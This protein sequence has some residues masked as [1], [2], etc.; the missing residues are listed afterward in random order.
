M[1]KEF[2]KNR[3]KHA[4]TPLTVVLLIFLIIWSLTL[5][6]LLAWSLITSFKVNRSVFEIDPFGFFIN[7]SKYLN[8]WSSDPSVRPD[9][10]YRFAFLQAQEEGFLPLYTYRHIFAD[11]FIKTDPQPG[12]PARNVGLLEMYRNTIL[13]AVGSSLTG[14][15]VPYITAYCCARFKYKFSK[16]LYTTV[17]I[18]MMIPIVGSTPS[19]IRLVQ[20]LGIINKVY[21]H[22]IMSANFLGLYFLIFYDVCKAFPE[23]YA[24]AAKMDGANNFQVFFRIATPLLRNTF[25]TVFLIK[26][27]TYWN[28][29][30]GALIYTPSY[31][32]LAAGLNRIMNSGADTLRFDHTATPARMA[33]VVMAALPV[34]IVF[35]IF[36]KRLLGNLTVGG[37]KG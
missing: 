19:E 10:F 30:Q 27:V 9:V 14:T 31:P 17:L 3:K 15:I 11:F 2:K 18:V 26:F 28:S 37:I 12:I 20:S 5:I 8:T 21:C 25:F 35:S 16:V 32:V 6:Y 29:Y 13:Y 36:Q 24:E 22:W 23:T 7:Y 4:F 1:S 33:A 34:C